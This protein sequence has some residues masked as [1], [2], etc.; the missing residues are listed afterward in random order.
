MH[1]LW[2]AITVAM[3]SWHQGKLFIEHAVRIDHDALHV[4]VGVLLWLV[5]ALI[6]RRPVTSWRPWLWLL[7]FILWNETVDL[8][9]ERWPEPAMQY[10]EGVRDVV[11]TMFLPLVLMFAARSRPDLLRGGSAKH[12]Q[13]R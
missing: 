10:G 1:Q 11:L 13:R 9:I 6:L 4:L 7:A 2:Y 5:L 8:W 3:V 12:R